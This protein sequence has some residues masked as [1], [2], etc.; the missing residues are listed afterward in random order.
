MRGALGRRV[1]TDWAHVER[2]PLRALSPRQAPHGVPVPIG[3]NWYEA[4][5]NPVRGDDRR[6]RIGSVHAG[7]GAVRG[8]HCVCLLPTGTA[9]LTTWWR[10]YD[11]GDEG[12]CVG[13]GCSRAMSLLNRKRYDARWLYR[14]AQ[15]I[16][17]YADTPPE[18]GTSV[19]AG[20]EVLRTY[21]HRVVRGLKVWQPRVGDGIAA[22]RWI[23]STDDLLYVLGREN[24]AEVP[25]LNSWG[26]SY[27]EIV[28]IPVSVLDRLLREDGEFGV[29][30]D[31]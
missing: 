10:F 21:G 12:A 27:P 24:A 29:I 19:R 18:E 1:P 3:V 26:T 25:L 9:D 7:L 14:N 4:F 23:T 2:Y 15:L 11:Q 31:R 28:W 8:G 20:L 5:D 30:T 6:Y 13:F 16:D 22:Y 17:E